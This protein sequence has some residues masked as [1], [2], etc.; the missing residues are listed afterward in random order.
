MRKPLPVAAL[1][2]G[3]LLFGLAASACGF[4]GGDDE[5]KEPD[6]YMG[7]VIMPPI[8]KPHAV[9]LNEEGEEWN[10]TTETEGYVTLLYVGY[11]H[12]PDICPTHLHEIDVALRQ[13]D[14][15]VS[16]RVK[17]IMATAD[18]ERDSPAQ[19]KQYLDTFNEGFIGLTGP[20]EL[21]DQFQ[22]ALGLQPATR[23][24]LG[25]GYYAVNHA[26]YVMAFTTDN[27]A[28]LVYP[29]GMGTAEWLNDLPLLVQKGYDPE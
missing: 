27:I 17:V 25:N 9:L 4:F 10:L 11:T 6:R 15:A 29:A 2:I 7:A 19:L 1:A 28:H 5:P 20:R 13:L 26:A 14:P 3:V 18:P 23:T 24:D 16:S 12:C 8:S 21:M 22:A